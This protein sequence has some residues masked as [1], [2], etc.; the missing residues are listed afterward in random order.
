MP[1]IDR[2]IRLLCLLVILCG[3]HISSRAYADDGTSSG[4]VSPVQMDAPQPG[5]TEREQWL[6]NRV[7]QL[8]KRVEELESKG[9]QPAVAVRRRLRARRG[10]GLVRRDLALGRRRGR[11]REREKERGGE[12]LRR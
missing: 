4:T 5:L 1:V 2:K 12:H 7:E 11:G 8:E 3:T 9:G 10:G 6:L